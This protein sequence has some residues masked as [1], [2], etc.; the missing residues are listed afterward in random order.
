MCSW[1]AELETEILCEE[2]KRKHLVE[3]HGVVSDSPGFKEANNYSLNMIHETMHR[4]LNKWKRDQEI[5][6][7]W[8]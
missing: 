8:V 1:D 7:G 5:L 2:A 3:V 4:S 6:N